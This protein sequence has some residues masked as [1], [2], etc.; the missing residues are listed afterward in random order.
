MVEF[1]V[2]GKQMIEKTVGKIGTGGIVYVPKAWIGQKVLII[3]DG[4]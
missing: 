2:K 3:L 4:E 1:K